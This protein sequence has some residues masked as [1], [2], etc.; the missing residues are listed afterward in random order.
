MVQAKVMEV[1]SVFHKLMSSVYEFEPES[2][3]F[4][5][6]FRFFRWIRRFFSDLFWVEVCTKSTSV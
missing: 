1:I 6:Y 2:I 5:F 4:F 3:P